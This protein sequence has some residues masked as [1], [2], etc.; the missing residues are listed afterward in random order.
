MLWLCLSRLEPDGSDTAEPVMQWLRGEKVAPGVAAHGRYF[1][2]HLPHQCAAHAGLAVPFPAQ[3]RRRRAARCAGRASARAHC[4]RRRHAALF[5][6]R[7]DG[8]ATRSCGRSSTMPSTC[9]ACSSRFWLTRRWPPAIRAARSVNTLRCRCAFGPMCGPATGRT[10][11]PRW[12]GSQLDG[13]GPHGDRGAPG[14]CAQ[15]GRSPADGHRADRDRA[16]LRGGPRCSGGRHW[17]VRGRA[18]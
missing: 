2:S 6:G 17:A 14:R 5:P 13:R 1:G 4:A 16:R 7:G 11:W 18:G 15:P 12:C 3:G 9:L 10:R 8:H